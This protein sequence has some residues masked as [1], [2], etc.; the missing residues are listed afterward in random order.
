MEDSREEGLMTS[1]GRVH[2]YVEQI[3]DHHGMIPAYWI[4]LKRL[5]Y[6]T[7][8]SMIPPR[9]LF[10]LFRTSNENR[11][12]QNRE[13]KQISKR[14]RNRQRLKTSV[15]EYVDIDWHLKRDDTLTWSWIRERE[16][17]K[18]RLNGKFCLTSM[19]TRD[20]SPYVDQ[21]TQWLRC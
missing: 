5:R 14:N 13:E 7:H 10:D 9:D 12:N 19:R 16:R 11:R 15:K 2:P 18:S 21:G 17:E 3:V 4:W 6:A 20:H 8:S 1:T